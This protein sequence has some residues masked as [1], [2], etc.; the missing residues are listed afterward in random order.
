M[1]PPH[2]P[3]LQLVVKNTVTRRG[4]TEIC[5]NC[6]RIAGNAYPHRGDR[7]V[8]EAGHRLLIASPACS[9]ASP[10]LRVRH[11]CTSLS[12]TDESVPRGQGQRSPL[13]DAPHAACGASTQVA[14]RRRRSARTAWPRLAGVHPDDNRRDPAQVGRIC[15]SADG[16]AVRRL[17]GGGQICRQT[18]DDRFLVLRCEPGQVQPLGEIQPVVTLRLP[19]DGLPA[20]GGAV[21]Y[22]NCER[23]Q[24]LNV[25]VV[26]VL[27]ESKS[28]RGRGYLKDRAVPLR[29]PGARQSVSDGTAYLAVE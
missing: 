13:N 2:K 1:A 15:R 16:D 6:C 14:R 10:T 28:S 22:S 5:Q 3:G 29:I 12:D 18:D 26:D 20:R 7:L 21:T 23:V 24:F 17:P 9:S 27:G 25:E 4:L 19:F 11:V 8:C